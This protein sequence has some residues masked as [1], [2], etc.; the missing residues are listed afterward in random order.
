[1]Y[2]PSC[3]NPL[4]ADSMYCSTCGVSAPV[5]R[6]E[7]IT[8]VDPRIAAIEKALGFKYKVLRKIG[9]GGFADVYLGEHAQLGREVAIKILTRSHSA[10]DE[11]VERFRRESKAAAKLSHPNIIDIYDVGES[12][13][14]YY[15]VMKYIA[16]ETLQKKLQREKKIPP[17]DAIYIVQQ[18]AD[19]LSY[20]HEHNVIHRDIKPANIMLDEYGK[21][22]LM[23]FGIA[24][25]QFGGQLTRTGTVMG[26]PH[27]L[28]PEQPLG[29]AVDGRS[30]LYSLGIVF[31]EML[32]GR[33]PFHDD[34]A[35]ALIYKHINE[36]APPLQEVVPELPQELCTIVHTMIEKL[37]EN[38]FQSASEVIEVLD[39]LAGIY[40]IRAT[41]SSRRSTPGIRKSTEKL[42]LLADEHMQQNKLDKALEIYAG[43]LRNHPDNIQVKQ[44]M[45]DGLQKLRESA[46]KLISQAEFTE[47]RSMIGRIERLASTDTRLILLKSDLETEEQKQKKQSEVKTNYDA[48]VLA[49]KHD[50]A[51]GAMDLLTKALTVDPTNIEA[52]ELLREAR[53]AYETNRRKAELANLVAEADYHLQHGSFDVAITAVKKALEIEQSPEVLL[54]QEKIQSAIKEK[55]NREAEQERISA[56]VDQL[57]EKLNFTGAQ[58]LLESVR[59]R[60]PELVKSSLGIV[61]RNRL[62]YQIFARGEELFKQKKFEEAR[63]SY[64]EFLRQPKPYDFQVFHSLRKR[65][66][67]TLKTIR[68][69]IDETEN[70]QRI[71]K[72][73]VFLRMGQFD[74]AREECEAILEKDKTHAGAAAKL[75]DIE[76]K[77]TALKVKSQG[78]D[79]GEVLKEVA[80]LQTVQVLR[81]TSPT[82]RTIQ[83]P[84]PV[85][86]PPVPAPKSQPVPAP[87]VRQS[88]PIGLLVGV[89]SVAI[90]AVL[91]FAFLLWNPGPELKTTSPINP[92]AGTV[93]SKEEP[94]PVVLQPLAVSINV[95]PWA[96]FE[97]RGNALTIPIKETTPAVVKLPPGK[98][99]IVFR[100]Q[101]FPSFNETIVVD[102]FNTSFR[103]QFKQLDPENLANSL[104]Q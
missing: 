3:G 89:G 42:V 52:N 47:A 30:D 43:I 84:P 10:E 57:C 49:L 48:A 53:S 79:T 95:T 99:T 26:T 14:I 35:I 2:C 13:E 60:H 29:K 11:M 19:A 93:T 67:E 50:N 33:V 83:P 56:E 55:T 68:M 100:N 46:S 86:I 94:K 12:G 18:V 90:L 74:L 62:L 63:A 24:R 97:I 8:P 36:A 76:E 64:Q 77:E 4:K 88:L 92:N 44:K 1:M 37:P 17:A 25:V 41:P 61:Q 54:L 31:Y 81:P 75:T 20:A 51:T 98:Y 102:Q 22:V 5:T 28:S 59:D 40:S 103:F 82:S 6:M 65:A 87:K 80:A 58:S 101:D 7:T 72:S 16:G 85:V 39:T 38:R 21:P 23:D 91:I 27:Y 70:E 73:D 15:F 45:E 104:V 9:S 34:S 66:E 69:R 96:N 71:K 32:A 78:P